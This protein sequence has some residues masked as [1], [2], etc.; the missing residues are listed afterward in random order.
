MT[1]HIY[2]S[3]PTRRLL[4]IY[5]HGFKG[6]DTTFQHFPTHVHNLLS[7][8]LPSHEIYTRVYPQYETRGEMQA[9][10][11][12]FSS[13]LSPHE[14]PDLDIILLGHSLGGILAADAAALTPTS[15]PTPT[16]G[17]QHHHHQ[18]QFQP[19]HRILGLIN[20]DVPFLGLQPRV[21]HTSLSS[22]FLQ[23]NFPGDDERPSTFATASANYVAPVM[24][25]VADDHG[26]EDEVSVGIDGI[27]VMGGLKKHFRQH[28][29]KKSEP[30]KS[31]VD[32]FAP[33]L[34]FA[35]CLNDS[36]E[37]RRRYAWL[38]ELEAA[39]DSPAR[40]RF[41]NYYAE[42]TGEGPKAG[43]SGA[44]RPVVRAAASESSLLGTGMGTGTVGELEGVSR[45]VSESGSA[46]MV[47]TGTGTGRKLRRFAVL[48]SKDGSGLWD[49]SL[50]VP[51]LME[52]MD[53]VTAHMSMF[54]AQGARYERL[55]GET[56]SQIEGWV[57]RDLDRRWL[58]HVRL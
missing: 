57:Q 3:A 7:T 55:V 58:Q 26:R 25:T 1:E 53:E 36:A 28:Q 10:V 45:S 44:A 39:E 27:G 2:H 30:K 6:S 35:N 12:Q 21:Y 22:F 56:V 37:L 46:E 50:W 38:M 8:L 47:G 51:V 31:L 24:V 43:A 14:S 18:P 54:V 23:K 42:S 16:G 33:S 20:F 41:V 5:I 4:L 17:A 9:A 49:D 15:T 40:V 13:W 48:P 52:D 32:R 29:K 11:A 34:K 19:K